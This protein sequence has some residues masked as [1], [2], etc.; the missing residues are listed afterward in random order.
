MAD[1]FARIDTRS[2]ILSIISR[3]V[4]NQKATLQAR[5]TATSQPGRVAR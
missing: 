3:V 2:E 4:A 5:T 1:E